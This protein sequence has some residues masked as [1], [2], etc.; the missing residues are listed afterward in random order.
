M[1]LK[2]SIKTSCTYGLLLLSLVGYDSVNFFLLI[3][4]HLLERI[5]KY[6]IITRNSQMIK[7]GTRLT[8]NG[9]SDL[10]NLKQTLA[11]KQ[12]S[13]LCVELY[14]NLIWNRNTPVP[15]IMQYFMYVTQLRTD[16]QM[17]C[18]DIHYASHHVGCRISGIF[19]WKTACI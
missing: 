5:W 1:I 9:R 13:T 12:K 8:I 7:H 15:S 10:S 18:I 17:S 4:W 19:Y 3:V 6:Q 11:L 14:Q 2:S 16:K